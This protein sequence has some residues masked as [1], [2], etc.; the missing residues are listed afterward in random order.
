[1]KKNLETSVLIVGGG[2]VGLALAVDLGWRGVDCVLIDQSDGKVLLPRASGISARTMEYCRRWGIVDQVKAAGFPL[3]YALSIAFCT[4]LAGHLLEKEEYPPLQAMKPLSFSPE[5]KHRCPQHMFDPV[6]EK[7]AL[8]HASVNLQRECRLEAFEETDNEVVAHVRRLNSASAYDFTAERFAVRAGPAQQSNDS[9]LG[10]L[11][12]IRCQYLVACDGV[13]S[14]VRTAL[15]I[16]LE[17]QPVL[18]YSVSALLRSPMLHRRHDKG[19]AE[20]YIFV[21]PEG[22]WG[23]LTVVDGRQDWRLTIAGSEQKMDLKNLDMAAYIRR[24]FGTDEYPFELKLITPW[25]RRQLVAK[26]YRQGR[27]FLAGDAVHAMSPTGGF[28]AGTGVGDSVDLSWKLEGALRGWAGSK[29]LDSYEL[30]RHPIGVRNSAAAANNFKPWQV[31][32]DFSKVL[33]E[34]PDGARA[35]TEIGRALKESFLGEWETWGTTMGYRYEGSPICVPDGTPA[36]PDNHMVYTQTARPGSRAPHAWLRDGR[37]TLDLFG[38]GFV[39]LRFGSAAPDPGMIEDEAL[40]RGLPFKVESIDQ[41]EIAALYERRLVLVRPDGH[42][43]WR[44]DDLPVDPKRVIDVVR[45]V[46]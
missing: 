46:L 29:L 41:P 30:E 37:S 27:V 17:G 22:V 11:F 19:E 20:R 1:M 43:A 45:G 12:T 28:G 39:L 26:K 4:S 14:G 13:E 18:S 3:D 15:N 42:V 5:N 31:K 24:C 25:R 23:N 7:V 36:F 2:P 8:S 10:E 32:L 38:R 35:R 9:T 33:D 44:S 6:L 40:R 16:G 21:G 34:S